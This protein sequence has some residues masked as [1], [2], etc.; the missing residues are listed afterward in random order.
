[1]KEIFFLLLTIYIYKPILLDAKI[2]TGILLVIESCIQNKDYDI[3]CA[4]RDVIFNLL[5]QDDIAKEDAN[6]T[7]NY[8]DTLY[9]CFSKDPS[10][11]SK[12]ISLDDS[13]SKD[14][15][16]FKMEFVS[17]KNSNIFCLKCRNLF[18]I[19]FT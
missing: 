4:L 7:I 19:M 13:T 2:D 5:Q 17:M 12:I 11:Q 18:F 10:N 1:M 6:I 3:L 9:D 14:S 15:K 8:I 16:Y